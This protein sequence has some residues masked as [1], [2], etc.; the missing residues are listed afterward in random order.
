MATNK[1]LFVT[2]EAYPLIKTG[3]L[4]DVAGSLPAALKAQRKDVRIIMPAY[5][6]AMRKAEKLGFVSFHM[7]GVPETVRL[8]EGR[9]PGT[10]VKLL[11]VD[12]PAHFDR[13]GGPYCDPDGHDWADNAERFATF[14]RAVTAV[15]LNKAE[16]D[17]QPDIVHCN[18]WQSGLVPALLSPH[19]NRPATI[20][21]IHNLA[22]HGHFDA[23]KF[24]SLKLP[25][26]LWG[27][28]GLEFHGGLSFIKGGLVFSDMINTVSPTYA[29]EI[30]TPH[31]GYG[32]NGLLNHRDDRLVGILN[33][34][35]YKQWNPANDPH[36]AY[37]FDSHH[38]EGKSKNKLALQKQFGLPQQADTPLLGLVGR[39]VEQKGIDLVLSIIPQLVELN[40]QL[41]VLGTGNKQFQAELEEAAAKYPQQVA[42]H[43][44]YSEAL[45]HQ[46]EAGAD[47]FLMPSRF[48]PC[49]LNQI[50]S[51]RYGTTPIVRHTGGL[52]DTVIDASDDNIK[53]GKASGFQF[54][55]ANAAELLRACERAISIYR[56]QPKAW[57]KIITTG[58]RQDFSWK[59]SAK[60]YLD[61]YQDAQ[62]LL[63]S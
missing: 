2:S 56:Q 45:A 16:L 4:G 55:H 44:G 9:L 26:Y 23:V 19:P 3:G 35:D 17:W 46:I 31:F 36:L 28:Q 37:H 48:E 6:D 51:L 61:L 58:M 60:H 49:G 43:V 13:P 50:Y 7:D 29:E 41:V 18:D 39:L 57:H 5:R 52:A 30:R 34:V 10:T 54:E 21:T 15:A 8:L 32:L 40:T 62:N 42:V 38:L 1:I 47:M 24:Q 27:M 12:S 59:Q 14:A 20:F 25:H 53:Q 63:P 33:G 11:L 22:Y